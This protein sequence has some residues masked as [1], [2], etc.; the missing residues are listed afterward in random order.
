MRKSIYFILILFIIFFPLTVSAGT[1]EE[2]L[3]GL[4]LKIAKNIER[5]DKRTVAVVDFTDLQGKATPSIK[6]ALAELP[7]R[8]I[9]V[10]LKEAINPGSLGWLLSE[11]HPETF[12]EKLELINNAFNSYP[13]TKKLSAR[14]IAKLKT[15]YLS[16][17]KLQSKRNVAVKNLYRDFRQTGLL[18]LFIRGM[19]IIWTQS[20]SPGLAP[21]FDQHLYKT[22]ILQSTAKS[23]SPDGHLSRTFELLQM[24]TIV[25]ELS[26]IPLTEPF[27]AYIENLFDQ[28]SVFKFMLVNRFDNILYFNKER[29]EALLDWLLLL[30]LW[31]G[32]DAASVVK[33][34][35]ATIERFKKVAK[36]SGY[37]LN[38]F[39]RMAQKETT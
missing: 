14:Q 22:Q 26:E 9:L 38:N 15:D 2:E 28:E 33:T 27:N 24:A 18:L 39:I 6:D 20:K 25:P 32:G 21:F 36:E 16:L 17:L 8:P 7:F 5:S 37:Q 10:A 35:Q 1:Y 23:Q 19:E 3:Q 11:A 34:K 31:L 4:S 13:G 12:I 29:F 30:S